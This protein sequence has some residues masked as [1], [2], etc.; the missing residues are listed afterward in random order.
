M[1]GLTDFR[2]GSEVSCS[3]GVC[4]VLARVVIDP[5]ARAL[6]HLVVEAKHGAA[7]GHLV[8][9][10]LVVSVSEGITLSCTTAQFEQLDAA[11]ET[12]FLPGGD[13][14]WG[15][16]QDQMLSRPYYGLGGPAFGMGGLGMGGGTGMGTPGPQMVTNDRVPLG[17][18]EV[19]RGDH[20][21]ATDGAIGRVQGLV[22][23]PGDHCVTH[24]LLDEGHLW[25][26]KKVAIPI[27]A[28]KDVEDGV[29]LNLSKDEVRDLPEVGLLGSTSVDGQK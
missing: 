21:H 4:G 15:Y 11:E 18:V 19:R 8:P 9:V 5:V 12:Q 27:S 17:E 23:H 26:Q 1:N 10:D 29:R 7:N 14:Q 13:G 20:V 22:V 25:G 16:G 24:V 2:I 6:T 3:D 28:V